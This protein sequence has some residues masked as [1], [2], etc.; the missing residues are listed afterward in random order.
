MIDWVLVPL[1]TQKEEELISEL[2]DAGKIVLLFVIDEK[3][4]ME[5]ASAVSEKIKEAETYLEKIKSEIKREKPNAV[6]SDYLEWGKWD[7]KINSIAKIEAIKTI[8]AKKNEEIELIAPKL[9]A[10]GFELKLV[11]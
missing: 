11:E 8:L 10:S 9:K 5:P 1:M 4:K 2:R 7:E 6:L 3:L